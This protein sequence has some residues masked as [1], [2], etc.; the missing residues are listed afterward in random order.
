MQHQ[1]QPPHDPRIAT[2]RGR[3]PPQH[4]LPPPYLHSPGA[5]DAA[6]RAAADPAYGSAGGVYSDGHEGYAIAAGTAGAD[7]G[8]GAGVEEP[9][10]AALGLDSLLGLLQWSAA[11]GL[12]TD[13][14]GA[15]QDDDDAGQGERGG[16]SAS[17]SGSED[18]EG[19][20]GWGGG[21]DEEGS[22]SG[23]HGEE[24]EWTRM[25]AGCEPECG[26]EELEGLGGGGSSMTEAS[27]N[28]GGCGGLCEK[29][30]AGRDEG[31]GCSAGGKSGAEGGYGCSGGEGSGGEGSGG[32]GA[33]LI[34]SLQDITSLLSQVSAVLGQ[35]IP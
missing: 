25:G 9:G 7:A 3:P 6:Q 33:T 24:E 28:L 26:P 31:G 22:E 13:G 11:A 5:F 35:P 20:D 23:S 17:G 18:G 21:D 19:G 2:C 4:Q 10:G 12:C 16:S 8:A 27:G 34:P 15:S 29:G 30:A 1:H 32:E 14:G